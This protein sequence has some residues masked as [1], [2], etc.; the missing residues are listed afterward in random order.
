MLTGIILLFADVPPQWFVAGGVA[1]ALG[2]DGS[3]IWLRWRGR[4][5]FCLGVSYA[6]SMGAPREV[7]GFETEA[8]EGRGDPRPAGKVTGA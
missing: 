4:R 1:F 2:G 6:M 8:A 3:L 5:R 7:R